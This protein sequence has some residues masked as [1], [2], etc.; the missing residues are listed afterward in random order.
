MKTVKLNRYAASESNGSV[1]KGGFVGGELYRY[2]ADGY[3]LCREDI[4]EQGNVVNNFDR[5]VLYDSAGRLVGEQFVRDGQVYR[6]VVAMYDEDGNEIG[7]SELYNK[8]VTEHVLREKRYLLESVKLRQL[9][10]GMKKWTSAL[11][12]Y[13]NG[14][15]S[16]LEIL[17]KNV[18]V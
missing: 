12:E 8:V 5:K 4:D 7:R 11:F 10:G 9:N 14:R 6:K 17:E 2:D 13:F 1:V 15:T 18:N 3:V 16:R